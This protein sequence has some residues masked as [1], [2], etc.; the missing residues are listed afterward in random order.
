ML[1]NF[2]QIKTVKTVEKCVFVQEPW[3]KI[4]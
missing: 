3:I 4:W 1:C 2:C